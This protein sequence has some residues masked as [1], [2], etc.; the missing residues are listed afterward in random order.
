MLTFF[1]PYLQFLDGAVWTLEQCLDGLGIH[2]ASL[3]QRIEPGRTMSFF[4]APVDGA[5]VLLFA[6]MIA[7]IVLWVMFLVA[8]Y[9]L[10]RRVGGGGMR[11]SHQAGQ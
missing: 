10:G 4:S 9:L 1:Y 6:A 11:I 3:V 2:P 5:A 8:G 7:A